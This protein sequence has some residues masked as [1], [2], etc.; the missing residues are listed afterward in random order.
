MGGLARFDGY[1]FRELRDRRG[2]AGRPSQRSARNPRRRV[3]DR[4]ERWTGALHP[5]GQAEKQPGELRRTRT[6]CRCLRAC[7][8]PTRRIDFANTITAL[9]EGADGTIWVG[10]SKG[11]HRLAGSGLERT[12]QPVDI[13]HAWLHGRTATGDGPV[14]RIDS[15]RFGSPRPTW[16]LPPLAGWHSGTLHGPGRFAR[17]L[18]PGRAPESRRPFLGRDRNG[19][20]FFFTADATH[21]APIVGEAFSRDE[22]LRYP[23]VN[24]IFETS[25][26]RLWIAGHSGL[27]EF[28]PKGDAQGRRLQV[29]T[30]RNGLTDFSGPV[31]D[32]GSGRQPLGQLNLER[33]DED[34]A[35][36]IHD[37][38]PRGRH[39]QCERHFSGSGWRCVFQR[40][41]ARHQA[42]Q[43]VRRRAA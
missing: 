30:Q 12:L 4:D 27:V 8:P 22:G 40:V 15:A 29:F 37:L 17:Q 32:R 2:T 6:S 18:F 31:A 10:T 43:R 42:G 11:L 28:F 21:A 9:R 36:R 38:R 1:S 39:R 33:C 14:S 19:G 41:R 35:A 16:A 24:Q 20:F 26:R 3:L 34:R 25:D 7:H 13:G 23:W 5:N